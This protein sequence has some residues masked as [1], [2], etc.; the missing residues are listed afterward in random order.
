MYRK[1]D[2]YKDGQRDMG[3]L[4]GEFVQILVAIEPGTVTTVHRDNACD[5]VSLSM[6]QA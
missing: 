6:G 3:E 5:E 4:I 2:R 1:F